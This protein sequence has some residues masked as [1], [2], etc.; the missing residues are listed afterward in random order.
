MARPL[1]YEAAGAC[2]HVVARGD[3]GRDVFEDDADG[4]SWLQLQE[5]ACGRF[6]WRIHAWVLMGH[7]CHLLVET[8]KA[9]LVAG[10][11]WL[12]GVFSQEWN[13]R[14]K[15]SGHVFQG[16]YRAAVVDGDD[17]EGLYLQ[18]VADYIHLNP[19]R[20]GLAGGAT[21]QRL[22]DYRW[23]SFPHY[24]GKKV[25]AWME[26]V[27]VLR[28]FG[29]DGKARGCRAYAAHL[30]SRATDHPATLG[31]EWLPALRRGWYLGDKSFAK[32]LL[33]S[34]AEG[35]RPKRQNGSLTGEA[36]RDHDQVEGERIVSAALTT[37]G[38]PQCVSELSG[39][40]K[41]LR[42]KALIAAIVRKRTG[43]RN[44]WVADRL[45]MGHESSVTRAV[46]QTANDAEM[47]AQQLEVEQTLENARIFDPQPPSGMKAAI[48]NS[49]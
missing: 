45:G 20:S 15:R 36:A 2:Y 7:H 10:M 37:L 3:G 21:G 24:T 42:E 43:V 17:Q 16:R 28:S 35:L 46:R 39:R 49:L 23:S 22:A 18:V 9:N 6:G 11:K 12:L 41:W 14:R 40:G 25:P 30:E 26:T 5:R 4:T 34:M 8:P 44:A 33:D 29:R 13:R 31:D 19:V 1:R 32:R 38:L 27:R 47:Q 48:M